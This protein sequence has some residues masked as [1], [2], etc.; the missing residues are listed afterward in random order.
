MAIPLVASATER[1]LSCPTQANLVP[2]ALK[3]TE[4]TQPPPWRLE[5][6]NSFKL[7]LKRSEIK[8][9]PYLF[10]NSAMSWLNGILAPQGVGEGLSSMS[11]T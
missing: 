7:R 5:V 6:Q 9:N 11:F 1:E 10:E 2:S 8:I 4:W 3:L